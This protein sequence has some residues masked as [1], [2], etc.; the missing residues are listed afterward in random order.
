MKASY[1]GGIPGYSFYI[2][3]TYETFADL[4]ADFNTASCP[5]HYGEYALVSAEG[6]R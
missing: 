2:T 1:Y 6:R 4:Q 3:K 5:V